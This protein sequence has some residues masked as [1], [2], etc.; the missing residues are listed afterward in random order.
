ML[1]RFLQTFR[2]G[3][4]SLLL[5]KLR[6]GLAV[7]GILIGVTAVIWLVAM[8]EGVSYQAQQQ[9]KELGATNII[10]R[11]IKPPDDSSRASTSRFV[12]Y[13][14]T[15]E[16][17]E[18]IVGN[19]PTVRDATPLREIHKESRYLDRAIDSTL[20]GCTPGYFAI[21]NL[22]L[23]RGR[24]ITDRDQ[25][26]VDNVCVVAAE[27]SAKLFPYE[28]PIGK[29]I[30]LD[31]DFY[32]IVGETA[33]REAT[34]SIGGSFS[35][36]D[37][38]QDV[39]VPLATLGARIG[40]KVLT[41]RSGSLEGE[42]VQLSQV[43]IT[44]GS[45]EEV[46]ETAG[47]VKLLLEKYHEQ[48]DYSI[49][50]PKELL[51]QAEIMR[52]MFNLLLVLIAGIALLVGGIG[53]MNI[54]LATVTERTREIGIRRALGAKQ[55]DIV[56]QFLSETIVLSATGGLLG[57]LLGFTCRPVVV[58]TRNLI[59]NLFPDIVASMPPNIRD[60]EPRI[61]PWSIIAAFGIS[62]G[63]GVVFGIYP[64]RRAAQMDP[65]EALRH[66]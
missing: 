35:G 59:M 10:I 53:I 8:G 50:V 58:Q 27:V 49:I 47:M 62:V 4:K 5:H 56:Q 48:S 38:N 41:A 19:I 7:L 55:R 51:R 20:V 39:Y 21:N 52:I 46:D 32:V 43:T 1:F 17:Y 37:Y 15:R 65:I 11:S 57:V 2:L 33:H 29:S 40:D 45:I 28:D 9:I 14:L 3:V 66:E 63:V 24:F 6:S 16:D 30:Q 44:V 18:R 34:G 12:E 26:R 60:L 64:A 42:I 31:R 23:R 54:M 22:K 36:K 61:A 13:G 25:D